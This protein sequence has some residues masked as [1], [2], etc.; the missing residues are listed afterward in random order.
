MSG[1]GG[2]ENSG[3]VSKTDGAN[4]RAVDVTG[5]PG[6][7]QTQVYPRKFCEQAVRLH[8]DAGAVEHIDDESSDSDYSHR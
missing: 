5:K 3:I 8:A 2:F 4:G 7:R 1:R 6:L